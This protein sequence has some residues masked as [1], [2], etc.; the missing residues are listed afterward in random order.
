MTKAD[1]VAELSRLRDAIVRRADKT[2]ATETETRLFD[3]IQFAL[4]A[5]EDGQAAARAV[6][7]EECAHTCD[8]EHEDSG[9]TSDDVL[10][11]LAKLFRERAKKE[12]TR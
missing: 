9:E 4:C 6:A 5:I 1:A 8:I 10:T 12:L 3:A 11:R 7:L 2:Q